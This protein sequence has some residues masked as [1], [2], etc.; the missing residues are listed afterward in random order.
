LQLVQGRGKLDFS[1]GALNV[2]S[3]TKMEPIKNLNELT[4]A[5]KRKYNDGDTFPNLRINL[6]GEIIIIDDNHLRKYKTNELN[7]C[8]GL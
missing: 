8:E 3:E 2:A 5:A 1:G 7:S 4:D 6:N